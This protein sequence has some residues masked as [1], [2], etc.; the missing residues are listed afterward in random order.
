MAQQ[1]VLP[2]L[3]AFDLACGVVLLWN[4]E[5]RLLQQSDSL[6]PNKTFEPLWF[7]EIQA[8]KV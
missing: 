1:S 2:A 7:D 8:D 4:R 5:G 6:A 3:G